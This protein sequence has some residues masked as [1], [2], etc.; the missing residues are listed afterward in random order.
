VQFRDAED[1][2][3]QFPALGTPGVKRIQGV[4]RPPEIFLVV[5][6]LTDKYDYFR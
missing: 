1:F 4:L 5:T 6:K 2:S 3:Q